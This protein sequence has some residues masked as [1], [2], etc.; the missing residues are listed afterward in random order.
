M[1]PLHLLPIYVLNMLFIKKIYYQTVMHG[2]NATLV[3]EKNK[4]FIPYNF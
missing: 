4:L 1:S 2:F 3:K